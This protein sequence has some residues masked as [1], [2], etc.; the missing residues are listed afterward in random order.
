MDQ[1]DDFLVDASGLDMSCSCG[2]IIA[3]SMQVTGLMV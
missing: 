1:M 3:M 2:R